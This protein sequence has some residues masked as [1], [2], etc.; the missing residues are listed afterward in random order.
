MEKTDADADADAGVRSDG[1]SLSDPAH[2]HRLQT[3]TGNEKADNCSLLLQSR[4]PSLTSLHIPV[5][6]IESALSS[7]AKTEVLSLS[8][9]GSFRGGLP[10]RPSSTRVKSSMRSLL[11]QRSLKAKNCSPDC[12]REVLIV[13]DIPSSD[14]TLHKPSASRSLSFNK[15]LFSSSTKTSNSL[16]VTPIAN[17][18]AETVHGSHPGSGP[19]L[20]KVE[21]KH[22][23]TRSFSVPVNIKSSSLKRTGSSGL[24]RVIS[25]R[26]HPAAVNGHSFDKAS[27]PE[28]VPAIEDATEDIPEEEAVCRICLMGL[29]EG[30]DTLKMECSCRGDLALAHQECAVKWFSIK[31]N[32]TCDVCKQDVQN[33]PVTLLKIQSPHPTAGRSSNTPQETEVSFHRIW[34]DVPVL[35]LVSM[36]AYFCFLEQLLVSDMG[37]RALAVSLPFACTFG[38]IAS[39]LASTLV[40]RD[41][42]WAYACFQFA[43]VILLAHV[44]YTIRKLNGILSVMLSSLAGFGIAMVVNYL[45]KEFLNWRF[46]RQIQSINHTLTEQEQGQHNRRQRQQQEQHQ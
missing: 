15:V 31:G 6:S 11:P 38:L 45:L 1:E 29:E 25:A 30:G 24:M 42:M 46:R 14:G 40:S 26:P 39:L 23:M 20:S 18:V 28:I 21:V 3:C 36:L 37:P 19:D 7:S 13:S 41:Y 34:Q 35:V 33:L 16:P 9:P 8:S 44:F 4:R 32:K 17:T 43:I 5:R 22:H 2:Y 27:V 10:P 12:E